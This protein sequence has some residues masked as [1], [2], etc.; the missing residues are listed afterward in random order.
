[1]NFSTLLTLSFAYLTS[2]FASELENQKYVEISSLDNIP[3]MAD[4][5]KSPYEKRLEEELRA[6]KINNMKKLEDEKIK[7]EISELN[8]QK[9][10]NDLIL[11]KEISALNH[12]EKLNNIIFE[13]EMLALNLEKKN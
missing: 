6:L 10:L 12:E 2:S 4:Y 5:V 9:Q 3:A 11:K 13:K 1:M 7:F 8:R